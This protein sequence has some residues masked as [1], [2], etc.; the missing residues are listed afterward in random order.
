[1]NTVARSIARD[2][3]DG[4]VA[5]RPE[6]APVVEIRNLVKRF[7]PVA[8]ADNV[9]LTLAAG[10][11]L[12]LLGESGSGKTTVLRCVAGLENA[13]SGTIRIGGTLVD[14]GERTVPPESR[15]IG[16]VFQSYALWPQMTALENVAFAG[17]REQKGSAARKAARE[18]GEHLLESVG[19]AR[20]K[21][22]LPSQLSGGQQQRVALARA[23]AGDVRL[24]L[25]D[26]PLSALDQALREE[27]R[28]GLR[29]QIQNSGLA[30][31]YV[32][33]DQEEALAMADELIVMRSGVIE[34]RGDPRAI[35]ERPATAFGAGF[36]GAKNMAR[37]RVAKVGTPLCVAEVAG[38][39]ISFSPVDS[40]A[41]GDEVELRWR[42]EHMRFTDAGDPT[43]RWQ[44]QVTSAV[45]LG[46][47]WEVGLNCLGVAM[48][49]WSES[50]I[51]GAVPVQVLP[52]LILGYA[53]GRS[54]R[55]NPADT[56]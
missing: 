50:E 27:L 10:K 38:E 24:L 23:L 11:T 49:A 56:S 34:E 52:M 42:R 5:A 15:R 22:R 36:L 8:A 31:L 20:M 19:L 44:A 54:A 16:M 7:G 17:T 25:M 1:M 43:N 26:E 55:G 39:M 47:R 6:A 4:R 53:L 37:G 35:Y 46:H 33:H 30:C 28:L 45:Y 21:D 2:E 40:V 13:T 3:R 18:Q 48:R 12:V 32:T 41:V 51:G 14:D 29:A 9:S